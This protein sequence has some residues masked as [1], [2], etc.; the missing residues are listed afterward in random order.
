MF[1]TRNP[2]R[3]HVPAILSPPTLKKIAL[4]TYLGAREGHRWA[5][6]VEK[7]AESRKGPLSLHD[8]ERPPTPGSAGAPA[9][10]PTTLR[11]RPT[12]PNNNIGIRAFVRAVHRVN[13]TLR[14]WSGRQP[15]VEP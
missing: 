13:K 11:L 15:F 3:N 10:A 2:N 7:L 14:L 1:P 12:R 8:P 4:G 9:G 5:T 6:N